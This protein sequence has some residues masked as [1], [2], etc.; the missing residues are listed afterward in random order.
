V[1]L[2]HCYDD[3][4]NVLNSCKGVL[5][6]CLVVAYWTKSKVSVI[7]WFLDVVWGTSL[8]SFLVF[9]FVNNCIN[10]SL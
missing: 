6:D 2:R 1:F 9:L 5:I 3:S 8:F 4:V 7:F 10:L